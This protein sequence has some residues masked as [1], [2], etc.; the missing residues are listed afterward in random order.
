[1]GMPAMAGVARLAQLRRAHPVQLVPVGLRVG[2]PEPKVHHHN[3][4]GLQLPRR[5]QQRQEP[6]NVR[7]GRMHHELP[8]AHVH[9]RQGAAHR[10]ARQGS[11]R[12]VTTAPRAGRR[13]T[14]PT[15]VQF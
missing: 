12:F 8:A 13:H 3:V 2:V 7:L 1:M 15:L 9:L 10:A 14:S 4:L 5:A 6:R 11:G